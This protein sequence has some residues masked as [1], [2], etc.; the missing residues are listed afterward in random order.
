MLTLLAGLL[1]GGGSYLQAQTLDASFLPTTLKA[2]LNA[3]SVQSAVNTVVVQPDGKVLAAGGF[4]YVNG[5]LTGKLQRFNVDG[6]VDATF[7]I[8][9][10]ANGFIAA[11]VLQPDGKILVAGSFTSFNGVT[12]TTVVRLN[13]NGSVDNT[14]SSAGVTLPRQ[15]TCMTV[16]P[17]GKVLLGGT[18]L[19]FDGQEYS[20]LTRL[21]AN[22]SKDTGF[23]PGTGADGGYL[24]ALLVQPDGKIMVGGLFSNFN[25]QPRSCL[26]RLEA[27]GS[28]DTSFDAG[29][30]A[31]F[32]GF[33]RTL[34]RQ[35]S[36]KLLVGGNI[37][38]NNTAH[39]LLRLL[40]TGA[41]DNT[42]T[43]ATTAT[44]GTITSIV[45]QSSGALL[46]VGTFSQ[47]EGTSRGRLARISADGVLDVS[48]APNIGA[49]NSVS[50]IAESSTGQLI[51]GGGF[52]QYNGTAQTALARLSASG[53]L[54]LGFAPLIESRGTVQQVVPL[55][56]GQLLVSGN[57]GSINDVALPGAAN[58][59]RR[60][61]ADGSVDASFAAATAGTVVAVAPI[62]AVNAGA[63]YVRDI[64]SP[65]VLRRLTP[66]GA[67]DNS[68][69]M[70]TL[71]GR[72]GPTGNNSLSVTLTGAVAQPDGKLLI[73]GT[74]TSYDGT[75]RNGVARLLAD[76][77]LDTSYVP[78][79]SATLPTS[80]LTMRRAT[81]VT[82]QPSGK[83]IYQWINYSSGLP[84]LTR[85]NLNGTED[86]TFAYGTGPAGPSGPLYG[87]AMVPQADGKIIVWNLGLT[88]FHGQPA[89]YGL[90]RLTVDG[91][92]DPTFS[93]LTKFYQPQHVQAD[94]RIL[95]TTA[96]PTRDNIT[97]QLARLNA[98]GSLDTSFS[99]VALPSSIFTG[100]DMLTG[101]TQQADGKT[102]VYGSFR[103]VAG[104]VRIGLAR[105]TTPTLST[106][107][108]RAVQPLILYP[109]PARQQATVQ[110]PAAA[111]QLRLLDLQGRLVQQQP[112]KARQAAA[113]LDLTTVKPGLYLVQVV[114]AAGVY[115][116]RVVVTR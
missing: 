107:A 45:P 25:G 102:I 5:E 37:N 83:L 67:L 34:A 75:P 85:L 88:S 86:N 43:P 103:Y 55:T 79:A 98:D 114:G 13:A 92:V 64:S 53:S 9:T 32:N 38:L 58:L 76:G 61:N 47:Y 20:A 15:P 8:G 69:T 29:S 44:N 91:A 56:G 31:T 60:L 36:G 54:D 110:L 112:L 115:Q 16:Q 62:G 10:G 12:N 82:V 101:V 109:N 87:F 65:V 52:S 94:G 95:V 46:L 105:L 48:F 78:P 81:A 51:I 4:D 18:Y 96:G 116:S 104:Q 49:N 80:T 22:G 74:F 35:A 42:F 89:P 99:P 68:F 17:D 3:A 84:T 28:L 77:S 2:P 50:A 113:S 30:A 63:V 27:D 24:Y 70:R 100:D 41:V 1:L 11:L 33:V 108:G 26:A 21:N 19:D 97:N 111:S 6:S 93:G 72:Y 39:R 71:A 59:P 7:N 14:F 66:G 90:T 106:K 57:V 73:Y 40:P 23:N